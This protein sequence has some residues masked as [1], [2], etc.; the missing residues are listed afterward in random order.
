MLELCWHLCD[1]DIIKKA[2]E[3]S[4]DELGKNCREVVSLRI[5]ESLIV[6][7]NQNKNKDAAT[8]GQKLELDPSNNCEDVL[9]Q[10]SEVSCFL[11]IICFLTFLILLLEA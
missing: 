9:R 2:P 5:L 1:S 6:K 3:V 8:V 4:D 11:L 10:I 7:G